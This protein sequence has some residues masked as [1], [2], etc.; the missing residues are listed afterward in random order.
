MIA[1]GEPG[2]DLQWLSSNSTDETIWLPKLVRP[3]LLR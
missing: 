1:D 3:G 2:F